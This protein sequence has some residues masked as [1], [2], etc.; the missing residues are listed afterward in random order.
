MAATVVAVAK[1]AR[2]QFSKDAAGSIR[3]VAGLGVEDDAHMGVTVKHVIRVQRDPTTPNL[4]QVHLMHRE[5]FEELAKQGFEV[6]PGALGENVTTAGIDLLDL[7]VGTRL[8]LGRHAVV[9]VTGL[10]NPCRQI[11]AFQPGLLAAVCHKGPDGQ[12]VR[13]S[14]IMS[15]VLAGGTVS[16]GD[17]IEVELPALPHRPQPVV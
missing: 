12:I 1:A 4:R 5:L 17:A 10:R 13:K 16:P 6:G 9:E 15:I 14:G 8:H 7:P 11:D 2:H 3:L